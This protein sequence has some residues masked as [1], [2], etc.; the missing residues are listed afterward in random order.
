MVSLVS[1]YPMVSLTLSMLTFN[2]TSSTSLNFAVTA[3]S[4]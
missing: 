2:W 1:S 4:P 3:G